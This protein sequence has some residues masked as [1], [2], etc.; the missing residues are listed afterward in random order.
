MEDSLLL[1]SC[2]GNPRFRSGTCNPFGPKNPIWNGKVPFEVGL[3]AP[4][5]YLKAPRFGLILGHTRVRIRRQKRRGPAD[6]LW[7]RQDYDIRRHYSHLDGDCSPFAYVA[8]ADN[9]RIP[10]GGSAGSGD[11]LKPTFLGSSPKM[12]L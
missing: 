9:R 12:L 2:R 11:V 10:P 5:N 4:E 6:L 8:P 7:V 3:F 1:L